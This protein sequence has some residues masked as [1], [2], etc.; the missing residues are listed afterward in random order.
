[1]AAKYLYK[2]SSTSQGLPYNLIKDNVY[3]VEKMNNGNVLI[4]GLF[5]KSDGGF[6]YNS[7]EFYV[8]MAKKHLTAWA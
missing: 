2:C 6:D 3:N 7:V 1:M 8:D 5:C 4:G